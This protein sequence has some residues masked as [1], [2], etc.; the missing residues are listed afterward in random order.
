MTEHDH[1]YLSEC[2]EAFPV[3][4]ELDLTPADGVI[5]ICL[6]CRDP[7]PFVCIECEEETNTAH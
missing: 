3:R 4:G 7:V 6:Q 1:E 5:G 2:C